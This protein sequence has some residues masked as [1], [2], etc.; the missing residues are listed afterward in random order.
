MWCCCGGGG[1][2][3]GGGVS[4]FGVSEVVYVCVCVRLRARGRGRCLC[5]IRLCGSGGVSEEGEATPN[6]PP[7]YDSRTGHAA[8]CVCEAVDLVLQRDF[9]NA[10]CAIRPPGHHAGRDGCAMDVSSQV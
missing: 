8:G 1:D 9:R 4:G 3:G 5:E 10:F 2:G 7:I 6:R